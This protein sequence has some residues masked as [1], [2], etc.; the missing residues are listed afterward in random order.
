[1]QQL[2]GH[3]LWYSLAFSGQVIIGPKDQS[4]PCG[5]LLP[6]L[7]TRPYSPPLTQVPHSTCMVKMANLIARVDTELSI[8]LRVRVTE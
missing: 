8:K 1:M 7:L 2:S 5:F 3:W 4:S 6:D